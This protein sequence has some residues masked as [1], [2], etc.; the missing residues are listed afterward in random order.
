MQ[1][2]SIGITFIALAFFVMAC[3]ENITGKLINPRDYLNTQGMSNE[4]STQMAFRGNLPAAILTRQ[5][6][7]YYLAAPSSQFEKW[8]NLP[9]MIK[10]EVLKN[11]QLLYPEELWVRQGNKWVKTSMP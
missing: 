6:K 2:I 11:P 9:L 8:V 3:S 4:F 7:V 1:K 10:G 5:N